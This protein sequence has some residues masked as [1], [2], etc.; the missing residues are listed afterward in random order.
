MGMTCKS[1]LGRILFLLGEM[2]LLGCAV[3]VKPA[4]EQSGTVLTRTPLVKE[5][6]DHSASATPAVV[7]DVG[8]LEGPASPNLAKPKAR[9]RIIV[10]TDIG[11]TDWDDYQSMVHL[12]VYG[13]L[14]DI[15]GI[16]ASPWGDGR[17][18]HVHDAI[19]AYEKDY[20]NLKTYSESYPTPAAL[21][22]IA[23]QGAIDPAGH[24]GFGASTEG[25]DWIIKRALHEDPRPLWVLV[26]GGIEDLAQALHDAPD[27]ESK[28]RV[29][30]IAGP[31]K[32]WSPDAYHY[33]A[34]HHPNLWFIE[35]NETY[36]GFFYG[37]IQKG[38]WTNKDFVE[39][40]VAD[41]GALG[42]YYASFHDYT[43]TKAWQKMGDT[44][45]VLYLF[46][47]NPEDPSAQGWGGSFVRAWERRYQLI[48]H[49]PT[50]EDKAE[51]FSILEIALPLGKKISKNAK[52][53]LR[54][55][56]QKLAGT[57][58]P[59]RTVHFRFAPRDAKEWELHV[60]SN[61][62]TIDGQLGRLTTYRPPVE[63]A[64]PS[65]KY[66][67][68][69]TD[70]P[71]PEAFEDPHIGAKTINRYRIE[72]LRDFAS[73]MLRCVAPKTQ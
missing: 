49:L 43:Q 4:S 65:P 31:N 1:K 52:V 55:E 11:G 62:P 67:N 45:S 26:W 71:A 33:I 30:F 57:F 58:Y 12:F 19:D 72:F 3:P 23:K 32:K 18:K 48:D 17:V 7:S 9:H 29:Y 10:S 34:T 22:A 41:R 38:E 66:P 6:T 39:T 24:L 50:L 36:R 44:P 16:I 69:W 61:V 64:Q 68:W 13:D 28:L 8:L 60:Q 42:K 40:H 70:N 56:N 73:R 27:I 15:E 51:Q 46:R 2:M 47:D 59:D 25:S 14:F 35:A 20:A 37:G 54:I 21:H 63:T 5:P 53:D